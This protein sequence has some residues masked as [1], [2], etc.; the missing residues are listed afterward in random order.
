M[1]RLAWIAALV[2]ATLSVL[3]LLWQFF[4]AVVIFLLALTV[5]AV[6]EPLVEW[7]QRRGLSRG[8]AVGLVYVALLLAAVV[9]GP[10]LG[11]LMLGEV[12]KAV[13]DFGEF[14]EYVDRQWAQGSPWQQLIARRLP[15]LE[16]VPRTLADLP[17]PMLFGRLSGISQSL[18]G[19]L[20]NLS[21]VYVL[22][23]Y[24][25]LDSQ[26]FER[27]WLSLLPLERRTRAQAAWQEI[28]KEVGAY[29]R[30]EL[31]QSLIAAVLLATVLGLIGFPYPISVAAVVAV[32]W[33]APWL[34]PAV[35]I[36]TVW[37][38]STMALGDLTFEA[39]LAR[40][41]IGSLAVLVVAVLLKKLVEPRLVDQ[42]AYSSFWMVLVVLGLFDSLGVAGLIL[43]PPIALTT[44]ILASHYVWQPA[45]E[46]PSAPAVDLS[47]MREKVA[48][49][50][51]QFRD[52]DEQSKLQ[53]ES[54]LDRLSG[55][56]DETGATIA[57]RS[58]HR[59]AAK[60]S[61]DQAD[62]E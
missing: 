30:S 19:L 31:L 34:G 42:Q 13:D 38:A 23:F 54:L 60:A 17:M 24:W 7:L 56:M 61:R 58:S 18:M 25:T 40:G 12:Q 27:L 26:R 52:L 39:N 8:S 9:L 48:D 37:I 2:L 15:H 11:N 51:S 53:M 46:P 5:A 47:E 1:I 16:A 59:A 3:A 62:N 35:A 50:R 22:S 10:P 43:G 4:E 21:V 6:L 20:I 57:A 14:Y 49:V 36:A 55:L 33:L 41:A 28:K 44:Q 29:M 45:V 32:A